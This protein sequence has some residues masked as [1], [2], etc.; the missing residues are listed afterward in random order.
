MLL[1]YGFEP[2]VAIHPANAGSAFQTHC[3][4]S[5]VL[6]MGSVTTEEKL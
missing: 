3:Q 4:G 6:W 5:L 1:L 2:G